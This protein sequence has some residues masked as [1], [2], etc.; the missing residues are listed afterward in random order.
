V[1]GDW[2]PRGGGPKAS[3]T[4]EFLP[5]G[6]P[7]ALVEFSIDTAVYRSDV[8]RSDLSPIV[9]AKPPKA[10]RSDGFGYWAGTAT[11][12]D[13]PLVSGEPYE[14]RDVIKRLVIKWDCHAES[15]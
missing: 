12:T 9:D 6:D 11:F 14:G 10:S 4:L 7:P 2:V 1:D 8:L 5:G 3:M 13:L 15:A